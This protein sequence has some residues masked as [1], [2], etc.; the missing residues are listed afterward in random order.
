M[1]AVAARG[2]LLVTGVLLSVA[3]IVSA[4]HAQD[5]GAAQPPS[6]AVVQALQETP[7]GPM[8]W[9]AIVE[10]IRQIGIRCYPVEN[11]TLAAELDQAN[12]QLGAMFL[13]RGWSSQQLEGFRRQ[14]GEAD[15]PTEVLCAN[16]DAAQMYR[17]FASADATDLRKTTEAMLA[18]PGPP[19]WGTCL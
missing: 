16:A 11:P 5:E 9:A 8:C 4:G 13:A 17:G 2:T 19:Q 15:T 3:V 18:R 1:R 6:G 12:A 7:M 14:M 10:S